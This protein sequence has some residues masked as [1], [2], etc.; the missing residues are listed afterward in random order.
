MKP[1][2]PRGFGRLAPEQRRRLASLGG[3][4]AHSTG[5]LHT[6]TAEERTAGSDK[7]QAV[8][9]ERGTRHAFTP[10]ERAAGRTAGHRTSRARRAAE[11]GTTANEA[12]SASPFAEDTREDEAATPEPGWFEHLYR[13]GPK[14]PV[15]ARI[16]VHPSGACWWETKLPGALISGAWAP[17]FEAAKAEAERAYRGQGP[18][19]VARSASPY[20][21]P[22]RE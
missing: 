1:K 10:E 7:A 13:L 17:N 22:D 21:A 3:R 9:K 2:A 20:P 6:F 19:G 11:T 15:L 12:Q 4:S 8:L 14:G 16:L 18:R 5:R